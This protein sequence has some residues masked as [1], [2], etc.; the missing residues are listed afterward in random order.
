MWLDAGYLCGELGA[1]CE[2]LGKLKEAEAH[3]A[4]AFGISERI[5]HT[6]LQELTSTDLARVRGTMKKKN[7]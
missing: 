1:F 5:G 4:K 7:E 6:R 3:F 2:K